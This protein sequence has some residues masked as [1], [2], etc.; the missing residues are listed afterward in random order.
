MPL[1]H[2]C[3]PGNPRKHG[4]DKPTCAAR[5]KIRC[6]Y[7]LFKDLVLFTLRYFIYVKQGMHYM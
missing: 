6:R 7:W 5:C 4:T 2:P 3:P 1:P